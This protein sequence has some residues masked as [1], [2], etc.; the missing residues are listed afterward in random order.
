MC[1]YCYCSDHMFK[2]DPPWRPIPGN[3]W[4][5]NIPDPVV[6]TLNPPW[7]VDRLAEFGELLKRIKVLEDRLG[8][9]CIE[10]EKPNYINLVED[11][12]IQLEERAGK[13]SS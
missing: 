7:G 12:I 5:P 3:P 13:H 10:P 8:C 4:H 1:I 9:E 11:R 6:P 2:F